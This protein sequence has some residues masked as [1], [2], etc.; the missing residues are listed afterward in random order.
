MGLLLLFSR[1]KSCRYINSR[2]LFGMSKAEHVFIGSVWLLTAAA[3]PHANIQGTSMKVNARKCRHVQKTNTFREKCAFPL[4]CS[5][6]IHTQTG[7][8]QLLNTHAQTHTHTHIQKHARINKHCYWQQ[9]VTPSLDLVVKCFLS[10]K[11]ALVCMISQH[12]WNT[13]R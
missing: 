11:P 8:M 6:T 5:P 4:M 7:R 2:C 1:A 13:A 9:E 10:I 3:S 12:N